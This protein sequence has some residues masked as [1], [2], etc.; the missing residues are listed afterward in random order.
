MSLTV[1]TEEQRE[2]QQLA[3]SFAADEVMPHAAGW[4]RDTE[5]PVA[6]ARRMGELGFLGMLIP[7]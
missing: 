6:V 1:L 5:F 7:E 4:D 2:I 3:R